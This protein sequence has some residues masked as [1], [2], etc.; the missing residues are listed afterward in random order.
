M[1]FP[2]IHTKPPSYLDKV[3]N[4]PRNLTYI[5][6]LLLRKLLPIKYLLEKFLEQES[7]NFLIG[8]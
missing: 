4:A 6:Y 2:L 5:Y 1:K 3:Q 7:L 8:G